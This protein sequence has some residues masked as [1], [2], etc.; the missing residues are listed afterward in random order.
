[1]CFGI[2][3]L[4]QHQVLKHRKADHFGMAPNVL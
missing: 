1:M 2:R 3:F 4:Q